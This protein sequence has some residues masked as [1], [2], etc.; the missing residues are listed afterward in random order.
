MY[1]NTSPPA[2]KEYSNR[3]ENWEL[4]GDFFVDTVLGRS[5]VII[6]D[7]SITVNRNLRGF[8]YEWT[9]VKGSFIHTGNFLT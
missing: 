3:L 9:Y 5:R 7:K 6:K 1:L 2:Y 8:Y 4:I